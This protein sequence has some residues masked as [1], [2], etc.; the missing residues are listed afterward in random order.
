MILTAAP[1]SQTLASSLTGR[2]L[3]LVI[4]SVKYPITKPHHKPQIIEI[5]APV[6]VA[7]NEHQ[8]GISLS[9][10]KSLLV[11]LS[12]N[13]TQNLDGKN[14]Y[15]TQAISG[16]VNNVDTINWIFNDFST[17]SSFFTLQKL[18]IKAVKIPEIIPTL[19]INNG[20]SSAPQCLFKSG[21]IEAITKA[22][23]VASANE[24]KRSAPIPATSPT[25]SPTLSAITA[26]FLGSSSGIPCS[27]LPTKS[28]PT[29]AA[30]V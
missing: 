22:A 19:L 5:N 4:Y 26:G 15:E 6:L 8:E 7:L 10:I 27:I 28:A 14:K 24:P 1:L 25:L 16:V 20:N 11:T 12:D 30:L 9:Q 17:S 3:W 13:S 29:S 18:G 23:Q 21:L 2:W